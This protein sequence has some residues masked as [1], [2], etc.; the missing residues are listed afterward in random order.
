M[1]EFKDS[2]GYSDYYVLHLPGNGKE[3]LNY[4]FDDSPKVSIAD[5]ITLI[6]IA[7]DNILSKCPLIDQLDHSEAKYINAAKYQENEK[8]WEAKDKLD[9]I[10]KSLEDVTTPYVMLMDAN[11]S[12]LLKDLDADFIERWKR[13]ECDM[14][15][16]ASDKLYPNL[17]CTDMECYTPF[18][19][20][21]LNAGVGFGLTEY[22]KSIYQ[23][24]LLESKSNNFA[25]Y[26]SEQ[27]Y[28]RI[29]WL[30]HDRIKIDDGEHL[31]LLSHGT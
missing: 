23:T 14:L 25:P 26:N 18:T 8:E 1:T 9:L 31:F 10:C 2:Y 20:H 11:D 3:N 13:Y 22:A 6:T 4:L 29:A 28:V 19:H 27:Y 7:T 24:A 21:Y 17:F 16:N 30:T 12:I 15:Y 5:N